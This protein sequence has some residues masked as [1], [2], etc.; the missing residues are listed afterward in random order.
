MQKQWGNMSIPDKIINKIT[1]GDFD[2]DG[3]PNKWD[4]QPKNYFNIVS[5]KSTS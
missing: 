3:T 4:C 1:T 5:K 2:K